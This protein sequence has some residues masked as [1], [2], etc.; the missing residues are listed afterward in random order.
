[1]PLMHKHAFDLQQLDLLNNFRFIL[2]KTSFLVLLQVVKQHIKRSLLE[3][4]LLYFG[5]FEM[6]GK[7]FVD[8]VS[9]HPVL[10]IFMINYNLL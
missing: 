3:K 10:L 4:E 9:V 5:L 6:F 2:N 8:P 7:T 1:M